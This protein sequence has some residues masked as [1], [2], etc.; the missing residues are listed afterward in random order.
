[1]VHPA[2]PMTAALISKANSHNAL[3]L[4]V[5]VK[6]LG[7]CTTYFTACARRN[8]FRLGRVGLDRKPWSPVGTDILRV[9]PLVVGDLTAVL[10]LILSHEF[11]G[12]APAEVG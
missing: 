10:R 6:P 9:H 5:G 11:A 12:T 4:I 3:R 8:S 2:S 7:G 1:M